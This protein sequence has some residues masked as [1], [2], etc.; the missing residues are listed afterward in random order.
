MKN[1]ELFVESAWVSGNFSGCVFDLALVCVFA[2][3]FSLLSLPW[4][5]IV[6]APSNLANSESC[7]LGAGLASEFDSGPHY[8]TE[9]LT[10]LGDSVLWWGKTKSKQFSSVQSLSHVQIFATPWIA[11]CHASLSVTNS[12]GLLKLMS[13]EL[14]TP[15]SHHIL[16]RPLHL[17]PP[18]PP[19]IRVFSNEST[20]CMRWPKYWSFSFQTTIAQITK[21]PNPTLSTIAAVSPLPIMAL[22]IH[23]SSCFQI[24][25]T[26]APD[27]RMTLFF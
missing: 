26:D 1:I 4:I 7:Q 3:A 8:S 27:R 18:I 6:A 23:G 16:C 22:V 11:A 5:S 15:S 20:L 2:L 19:S 21:W 17:L 10:E 14:V 25:I 24:Q 12:R 13:I 9:Q